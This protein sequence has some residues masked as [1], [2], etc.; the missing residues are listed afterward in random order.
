MSDPGTRGRPRRV[1]TDER[2]MRA[3]IELL[4]EKGP[5]AVSIEAVA[6]RSGVARTTIYRRF[7]NRR[8]LI[9]AAIDPVVDR[10]LPPLDLALEGKVRW[11]LEQV[12]ELFETGLGRGAVAAI[13]SNSDPDF[14]GALRQSL[15]RRLGALRAQIAADID[16]EQVAPHVEPDALIGLLFGAYLGE[17]LRHSE[18]R[19]GWTN[20]TVALLTRALAVRPAAP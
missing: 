18:P 9:E 17:V 1:E 8:Q 3:A 11:V 15:E 7:D 13:I 20:H 12:A 4:R 10:P 5:A 19:K 2:L 16:A 6:S 14:T